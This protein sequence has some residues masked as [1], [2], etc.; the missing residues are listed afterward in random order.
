M[1]WVTRGRHKIDRVACPWPIKR[2]IDPS[3]E[4]IYVPA[5]DV[6]RIAA[7]TGATRFDNH[8]AELI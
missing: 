4:F 5:N 3:A 8:G 7:E 2:F 1:Q 6:L